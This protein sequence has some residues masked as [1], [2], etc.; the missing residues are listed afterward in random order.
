MIQIRKIQHAFT[1]VLVLC[2]FSFV[3][4]VERAEASTILNLNANLVGS[5]TGPDEVL[6]LLGPGTYL[7]HQI[8]I[9]DGGLW[10]GWSAWP[11]NSCP[12]CRFQSSYEIAILSHGTGFNHYWD[13]HFYDTA[14]EALSHRIDAT[15]TLTAAEE[16]HFGLNDCPGCLGDNRGGMS[17][18]ITDVPEPT[19]LVLLGSGLVI[20]LGNRRF[21]RR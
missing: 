13:G 10:D 9:A 5:A 1:A 17:L 4:C 8:G 20:L 15:F 2:L 14:L 19:S 11:S 7:V 6:L 12:D 18:L 3:L 21:R 16:V